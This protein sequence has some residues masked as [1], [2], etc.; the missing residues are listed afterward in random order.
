MWEIYFQL[1]FEGLNTWNLYVN[2]MR[3]DRFASGFCF[4]VLICRKFCCFFKSIKSLFTNKNGILSHFMTEQ[5]NYF[6]QTFT[7]FT[8]QFNNQ[9][10]KTN[11]FFMCTQFALKVECLI[12]WKSKPFI[13]LRMKRNEKI[14]SNQSMATN[15][16]TIFSFYDTLTA[17]HEWSKIEVTVQQSILTNAILDRRKKQIH[18]D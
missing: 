1:L 12:Q 18:N 5:S 6:A 15:I 9:N 4:W 16:Q 2:W 14:T 17:N 7:F 10:N 13:E 3:C 8:H 11:H